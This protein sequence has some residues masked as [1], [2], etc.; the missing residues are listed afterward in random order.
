MATSTATIHT[1]STIDHPTLAQQHFTDAYDLENPLTAIH[2][3]ARIMLAHTRAQMA[4]SAA[5]S[6]TNPI[7]VLATLNSETSNG[8][9][10]SVESRV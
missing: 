10:R 4:R 5:G 3:Y 6:K 2:D 8:S 1:T 9:V 7:P